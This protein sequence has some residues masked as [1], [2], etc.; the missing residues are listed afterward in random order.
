MLGKCANP[1]CPAAFRYLHEGKVYLVD[2]KAAFAKRKT[3]TSGKLAGALY[4]R[5]YYW[6][7]ASCSRD[8]TIQIDGNYRVRVTLKRTA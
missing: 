1:G 5:E 2:C 4:K 3:G 7:C 8:L 6:L